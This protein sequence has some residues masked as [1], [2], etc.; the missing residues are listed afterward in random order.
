MPRPLTGGPPDGD[1]MPSQQ[2][3][4]HLCV[5][6]HPV[7]TFGLGFGLTRALLTGGRGIQ[8][9]NPFVALT[10][11]GISTVVVTGA[12]GNLGRRVTSYLAGRPIVDRVLAVDLVPM[13]ATAPEVEV[14]AFDLSSPGAADELAALG[15][16][17]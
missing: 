7:F 8:G 17:G 15:K 5:S 11:I 1:L 10:L 16:A 6:A 3:T 12:A 2:V 14:H 13:P 9:G 4:G